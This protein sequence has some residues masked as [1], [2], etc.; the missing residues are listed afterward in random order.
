MKEE[1]DAGSTA[2]AK[3]DSFDGCVHDVGCRPPAVFARGSVLEDGMRI[4]RF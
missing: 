4:E 1:D 3:E 2:A